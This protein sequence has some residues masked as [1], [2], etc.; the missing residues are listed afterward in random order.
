MPPPT[1]DG[2]PSEG[3]RTG[4]CQAEV[5]AAPEFLVRRGALASRVIPHHL[6]PLE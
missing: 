4:V 1:L 6:D 2:R 3:V 5:D